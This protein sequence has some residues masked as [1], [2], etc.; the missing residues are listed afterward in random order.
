MSKDISTTLTKPSRFIG[1]S[2]A[3]Q[4]PFIKGYFYVFFN[5][6]KIITSQSDTYKSIS[7]NGS[8]VLMSL[9]E[10][11]QPPGD[12]QIKYEDVN[13]MGGV[14]ASFVTGQTIDRNFSLN[15]RDIWGAPIF[16]IHRA[17]TSIIDPYTGGL[18]KNDNIKDFQY[19]PAEY[20]GQVLIVQTKPLAIQASSVDVTADDI[21]KVD[22]MDGVVPLTDLSSVYDSNITDNS[23]V[24]PSVQYRFD[25]MKWDETTIDMDGVAAFLKNNIAGKEVSALTPSYTGL[26]E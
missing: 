18:L 5:F 17:W 1:G 15:Y 10:G 8:N 4:H 26:T 24:K 22:L 16:R 2:T 12:R 14:D 11:Y 21:I 13:G 9:C 20:K 19:I 25:G 7:D 6:P 23:I 3:T